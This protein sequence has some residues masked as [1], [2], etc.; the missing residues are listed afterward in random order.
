MY[1][2]AESGMNKFDVEDMQGA[3]FGPIDEKKKLATAYE[4][5]ISMFSDIKDLLCMVCTL[6]NLDNCKM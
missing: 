4:N 6:N 5:L 2:D 3:I 1:D